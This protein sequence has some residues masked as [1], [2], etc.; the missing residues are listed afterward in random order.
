MASVRM[1]GSFPIDRLTAREREVA[2]G[3]AR[4]FTNKQIGRELG[5][6]PSHG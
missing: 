5:I 2:M 6:Q 4:G 1:A 3:L